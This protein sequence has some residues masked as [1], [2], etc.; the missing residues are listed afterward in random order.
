MSDEIIVTPICGIAR[1][2]HIYKPDT[3]GKYA[4]NKYKLSVMFPKDGPGVVEFVEKMTT[5]TADSD[6]D[7]VKDGD[8]VYKKKLK[9][10]PEKAKKLEGLQGH[11]IITAKTKHQP[12]LKGQDGKA[13]NGVERIEP[14]DLVQMGVKL[15]KQ[16]EVAGKE[17]YPVYLQVVRLVKKRNGADGSRY[18]DVFDAIED[19]PTAVNDGDF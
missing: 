13:L 11:F 16:F 14:G 19:E 15:G 2:P 10:D 1:F 8:E 17:G 3:E 9:K 18:D 4:D 12:E 7:I 5:L 6:F